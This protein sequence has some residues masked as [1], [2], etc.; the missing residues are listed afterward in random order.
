MVVPSYLWPLLIAFALI[1]FFFSMESFLRFGAEAKSLESFGADKKTTRILRRAFGFNILCLPA[2]FLLNW[3]NIGVLPNR[4]P[5]QLTG[6]LLM[7]GGLMIRITATL[8]LREYYTRTL[9]ITE[10][11]KI[12]KKGWYKYIRHPGYLGVIILW[13]GAGLS[14]GNL[15]LCI[16]MTALIWIVYL[17]RIRSEEEMLVHSFGEEYLEYRRRTWK[18]IPLI[19]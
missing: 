17:Y 15:I 13:T 4:F 1:I 6:N 18:L 16:L 2:A 19:F 14:T 12:V 11:H 9:R 5:V 7:T 8:I 10:N 3:L